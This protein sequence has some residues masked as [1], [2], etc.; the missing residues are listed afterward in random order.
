M[1]NP[2]EDQQSKPPPPPPRIS[3]LASPSTSHSTS[4]T[5]LPSSQRLPA[6]LVASSDTTHHNNIY[7]LSNET[8]GNDSEVPPSYEETRLAEPD[9]ARFGRWRNWVEKRGN[10]RRE[11]RDEL[12]QSGKLE[13]S[14]WTL[15]D[16]GLD[17]GNRVGQRGE[18]AHVDDEERERARM[19]DDQMEK[20]LLAA[21]NPYR[22]SNPDPSSLLQPS[23]SADQQQER[24]SRS[25]S[26]ASGGGAMKHRLTKNVTIEQ[27]GSRFDRGL[28]DQ[29]LCGMVLPT[30]SPSPKTAGE[31]DRFLLIGT[32]AG[33]YLADLDPVLSSS[34][35]LRTSPSPSS[36]SNSPA[37]I[38]PIWTGL[39]VHHLDCFVEDAKPKSDGAK[40]LLLALISNGGELEIRMWSIA[41][42]I[43][44]VKWRTYNE[45]RLPNPYLESGLT[46]DRT[47]T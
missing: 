10:E 4:T 5:P 39:A 21:S 28:P 34:A 46:R 2:Q 11:E 1:A 38:I 7:A 40:G 19:R 24:R 37:R 12:K 3:S 43:N 13:K 14:S 23:T 22:V 26:S 15:P 30:Q 29:P 9:N 35:P 41:A 20:R 16:E 32:R 36:P 45:V 33:L 25:S 17:N 6:G 18:E 47:L 31:P 42:I 44:L 8:G 27:L